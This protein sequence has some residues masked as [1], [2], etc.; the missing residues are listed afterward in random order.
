[1]KLVTSLAAA[2]L[3]CTGAAFA[4]NADLGNVLDHDAM[5]ALKDAQVFG[6]PNPQPQVGGE[7][8]ATAA[9]IPVLPYSDS[10]NTC[11]YLHNYDEACPYTGSLA[12][13]VVYKY[14]PGADTEV[15]ISLCN[16]LYDTKLFVYENAAGNLVA[17][18]DDA[19]G[20]DGFRSELTCVPMTA[21]NTYYIIVDGYSSACGDYALDVTECVPCVV[22]CPPNSVDEG[23]GDCYTDYND[24]Y[25]GGCNSSPN[26]FT[27]TPC[28]AAGTAVTICGIGGGFT[29]QGLDYRDTDWYEFPAAQNPGGINACLTIE[30]SAFFALLLQDCVNIQ[31]IDSVSVP[32]CTT[33]CLFVPAGGDYWIFVGVD[34][35]G[36]AV[37]CGR[38]YTLELTGS[39]CGPTS[40]EPASW[41]SIKDLYR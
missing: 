33:T 19:C 15:D 36:N 7:D 21:G 26:V 22:T 37:G 25:N 18:N 2:L 27:A 5:M 34:A 10:G 14:S 35:F 20:S 13:D 38:D 40:V 29:Y 12:G 11:A 17:C 39:T 31:V 28:N 41:G 6:T 3:L 30:H 16:S 8:I 23:E 9:N 24:Q 32:E 1:M 4:A